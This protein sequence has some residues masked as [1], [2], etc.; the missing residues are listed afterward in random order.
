MPAALRDIDESFDPQLVREKLQ[1][2]YA[3]SKYVAEQLVKRSQ[4]RGLPS[5][6]YRLGNQAAAASN[7]EGAW[8]EHDFTY[9]MLLAVIAVGKAP[10]VEWEASGHEAEEAII[11][12]NGQY[13]AGR[14]DARRLLVP[15]HLRTRDQFVLSTRREDLPFDEQSRRLKDFSRRKNN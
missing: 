11:I 2:G 8:N 3:Q 12:I 10:N 5:I 15:F 7:D 13:F 9:L 14:D 4:S 1:D 6:V